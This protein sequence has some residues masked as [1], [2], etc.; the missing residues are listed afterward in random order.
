M[1]GLLDIGKIEKTVT[2]RGTQVQVTGIKLKDLVDLISKNLDL[3][4]VIGG[5]NLETGIKIAKLGPDV[6]GA[7]IAAGIGYPND[8]EQV[9]AAADLLPGEQ[10][11]LILAICDVSLSGD[12]GPFVEKLNR[13]G[14]VDAIKRAFK[15]IGKGSD[16][17]SQPQPPSSSQSADIP[18]S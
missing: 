6:I 4:G 10:M 13:F 3:G 2:I 7:V 8:S 11:D 16:T 5:S 1:V 9:K 15:D 12:V 17:T 14:I 18:P